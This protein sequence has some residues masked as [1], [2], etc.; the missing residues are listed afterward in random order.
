MDV[1]QHFSLNLQATYLS[2]KS[3]HDYN[4]KGLFMR[5][6]LYINYLHGQSFLGTLVFTHFYTDLFCF[7][8]LQNLNLIYLM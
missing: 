5:F 3:C 2:V 4:F 1:F 8:L 7:Q 6:L